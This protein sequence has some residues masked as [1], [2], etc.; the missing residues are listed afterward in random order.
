MTA[1][2]VEQTAERRIGDRVMRLVRDDITTMDVDAFVIGH[3][4]VVAWR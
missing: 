4:G 1:T 2:T 3:L